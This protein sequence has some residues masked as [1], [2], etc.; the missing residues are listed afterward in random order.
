MNRIIT[1]I[2]IM[3]IAGAISAVAQGGTG[4]SIKYYG[5]GEIG[6]FTKDAVLFTNREHAVAECPE[7]LK[8][9]SFLR[10]DIESVHFSVVKG[11]ML[12][13][14][15]PHKDAD[16]GSQY[17]SLEQEGFSLL[18]DEPFQLF[19]VQDWNRVVAYTKEVQ[20][21]QRYRFGKYTV[22]MGF[23]D[24]K[25]VETKPWSENSGEL[26]YNG[27]R[28]PELWPP[29]DI[30]PTDESPMAVPYLE[31]PPKVIPID[32]GRQL[33]FDDFLI[34]QTDL[35]RSFHKPEKYEGNPILKPETE[36]EINAIRTVPR[37]KGEPGNAAAVPKSGGVWWDP[38]DKLFK[39]WY[40]AGWI[41]TIAMATSK[42]GIN[43]HRPEFDINPGTNQVLPEDLTA[44]SWTVVRNWHGDNPQEK[45]TMFM[46]PPGATGPGWALT[47]ADGIHWDNR[48]PTGN[49]G[50]R[51]THFYNPF[52]RKW[53]YSIRAA[54]GGRGRA[55]H[56]YECDDFMEGADWKDGERAVWLMADEKDPLD[57]LTREKPQM[58]NFDAAGYESIM[59]GFFEIHHG[60][61]N[62]D[63]EVAG[64]PKITELM[65][66]YSRDGFHWDRPDRRAHIAAE[67]S[68][69]WDRGYVQ[70]I[71]NICTVRG[72][73]LWFYYSA[74]QGNVEKKNRD[75]FGFF[76]NGMYDRG[77][78]GVAFM[79]RDGFASLDAGSEG[80]NLTTRPV[81]FSGKYLF[82]NADTRGGEI[83]AEIQDAGGNAIEPFTL[84]NS[85]PFTGD[86][87]IEMLHWDGGSD[88]SKL[89]GKPLRLHFELTD[90]SLYSFWVSKDGSGRSDGYVAGGGPGF[91][92]PTDTVGKASYQEHREIQKKTK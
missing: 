5:K 24:A 61:N 66:A 70:S 7:S 17:K 82:V 26:L 32:V 14:L 77:S 49:A 72:D 45:W 68:D 28:L 40:E 27:I 42:D 2:F 25:K 91:T 83:R 19:S 75:L 87:T 69:V 85:I 84:E 1:G 71:G 48:T 74:F 38:D 76:V 89:A 12:T 60:P 44:D 41:G 67:R 79:R 37:G 58:Y 9:E 20:S 6:V 22:V 86:S 55:R 92:G 50:D 52:R 65:F 8:G 29:Y 90:G 64:L 10:T 36:L 80:G 31:H 59:L 13:V 63:C 21:G 54:F 23:D 73:K 56:Y 15:T 18:A 47:S 30:D 46:Q 78:T 51:S 62:R 33:L 43:W 53:V 57:Y 3:V 39:M 81:E 16:T 4:A 88:I 35:K 11:G 34:E